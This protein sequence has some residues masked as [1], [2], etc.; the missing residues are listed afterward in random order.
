MKIGF[1][2]DSFCQTVDT[3]KF[4]FTSYLKKL[5]DHY[6]AD[7]VHTGVAGSSIGD[8][9]LNQLPDYINV[10]DIFVFVWTDPPRLFNQ[11]I[12]NINPGS[13]EHHSGPIW[14]AARDYYKYLHDDR[15][16]IIQYIALL[17]YID[18][19]VLP[20]ILPTSKIIHLWSF[21]GFYDKDYYYKWKSGVEIRPALW[22]VAT[23]PVDGQPITIDLANATPNHLK[24]DE[25]NDLVFT[26]IREAIDNY[27][28][29]KLLTKEINYESTTI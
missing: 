17:E 27:S 3:R 14:Q 7:I 15:L 18:N 28:N 9:L 16:S 11:N 25:R 13:I 4:R 29:G 8:V 21:K 2:G 5:A 10:P 19:N 6:N 24:G 12:R 20:S 26:W 22:N 1:F 23:T